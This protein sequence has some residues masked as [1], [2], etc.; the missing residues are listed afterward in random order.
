MLLR[1]T[2][3]QNHNSYYT[4]Q[5]TNFDPAPHV[6]EVLNARDPLGALAQLREWHS[7]LEGAVD[8]VVSTHHNSFSRSIQNYADIVHLFER[9]QGD[10]SSL[11][12]MFDETR[13]RLAVGVDHHSAIKTA[14]SH[15][16]VLQE[17]TKRLEEVE[18]LTHVPEKIRSLLSHGQ[19]LPAVELV[20]ASCSKLTS[21]EYASVDVALQDLRRE[22]NACREIVR[23]QVFSELVKTIFCRHLKCRRASETLWMCGASSHGWSSQ[24]KDDYDDL[25]SSED[26]GESCGLRFD[27]EV[28]DEFLLETA[29]DAQER[30]QEGI[31]RQINYLV[32][33][34]LGLG[35][36]SH[37]CTTLEHTVYTE[38]FE[39]VRDELLHCRARKDVLASM[40]AEVTQKKEDAFDEEEGFPVAELVIDHI[41]CLFRLVLLNLARLELQLGERRFVSCAVQ[42][43][44][45]SFMRAVDGMLLQLDGNF[46]TGTTKTT[47]HRQ[48]DSWHSSSGGA[49]EDEEASELP[50]FV[51]H[52]AREH[53]DNFDGGSIN[54]RDEKN[55]AENSDAV[56]IAAQNLRAALGVSTMPH[57]GD[58]D[59]HLVRELLAEITPPLPKA[60]GNT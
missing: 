46:E 9:S 50:T 38:V 35:D 43:M 3:T 31:S 16:I 41:F 15:S 5:E 37:A 34:M 33:C 36:V 52:G 28:D 58:F 7:T 30:Y 55:G 44:E 13:T 42:A 6:S 54:R 56:Y 45:T 1:L 21:S 24:T 40:A 26:E 23:N 51:F 12:T 17:L 10:V 60:D 53:G 29:R 14:W 59:V 2:E 19:Y 39:L 49:S 20:V 11:R 18:R 32:T 57:L 47:L 25:D 27:G 22:C 4:N 48:G 8:D